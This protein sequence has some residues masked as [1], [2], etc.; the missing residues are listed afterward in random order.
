MATIDSRTVNLKDGREVVLR[1][2]REDDAAVLLEFARTVF[3]DGEGM[4]L[5]PEEFI[6]TEEEQKAWIRALNDN[7]RQLLL[8]ADAGGVIVGN[9]DFHIGKRR[10]LAHSGSF[11]M[12]VRSGWRGFGVGNVLLKSL[13]E[14]A[15]SVPE[16][17]KI[18]LGVR[19]DNPRA[20][21]LYKKHGFVQSGCSRD[22][23]KMGDGSF[24]DDL[25]MEMFVR[26]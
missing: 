4:I 18:T 10:R 19:A 17:E 25:W 3:L 11:G 12:S 16:I 22:A 24:V 14:W 15:R 9:I 5:E 6:K 13:V 1:C 2:A 21:A 7:P 26:S 23:I 20:I 8:I